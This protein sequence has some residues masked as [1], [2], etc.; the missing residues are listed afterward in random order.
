MT[1]NCHFLLRSF[2]EFSLPF[3]CV[4]LCDCLC[5]P[6]FG[7]EGFVMD[8]ENELKQERGEVR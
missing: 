4:L 5:G 6:L 3:R 1:H 2:F 8:G 7:V